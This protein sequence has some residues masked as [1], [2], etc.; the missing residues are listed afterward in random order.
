VS[1]KENKELVS[2]YLLLEGAQVKAMIKAKTDDFHAPEFIY[3]GT[4]GDLDL[5]GYYQLMETTTGVFPDYKNVVEDIVTQ[6]DRVA[7]RYKFN[8]TH[9]KAYMGIP[10]TGKKVSMASIWIFR[11]KDGKIAEV[12]S[13]TDNLGLMQQLGA[14]PSGVKN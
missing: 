9:K 13:V 5:K 8:G 7:A 6:G 1:T 11:I 10:P 4:I 3:H 12:W 14:I 2:R